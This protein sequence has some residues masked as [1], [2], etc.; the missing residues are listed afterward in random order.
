MDVKKLR[1]VV[2]PYDWG[3]TDFLPSLLGIP[4][5][6]GRKAEYWMGSHPSGEAMLEH[7]VKLSSFLSSHPE[8]CFGAAHIRRFGPVL[9]FLLKVLS[10]ERP[11][12][13]QCHPTKE[14]AERGW[15]KEAALRQK[16]PDPSHWDY[17]DGNQKA[18]VLYALTPVTAMCAFRPMEEIEAYLSPLMPL[19]FSRWFSGIPKGDAGL[20][21]LFTALYTM[22]KRDLSSVIAEYID[23]LK[24][25]DLPVATADGRFLEAKGIALSCHEAYPVDP[26][27]FCPF[28]LH[29]VHLEPGEALFLKPDTLHAYVVGDGIELMSAS[30]NVLR[31]GLTHKKVDVPELLSI[32]EMHG[33]EVEKCRQRED[34]AGRMRIV[35]PTPDF[36]LYSAGD[37]MHEVK[38]HAIELML[39]TEGKAVFESSSRV[40]VFR[41]GECYLVPY[42][43]GPYTLTVEGRLF[44]ATTGA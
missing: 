18:E 16:D 14:Q 5:D 26:G 22:D 10:I 4:R 9:P 34:T 31:G 28:L 42:D 44:V 36:A 3:K 12:S 21:R 19:S 13:I 7:G 15:T 8:E 17:Q 11:L 41:K 43:A 27:L 40:S 32:L 23:G 2:K 20:Q 30:D 6:G 35:T 37:G 24:R 29:V 33:G 39:V 25:S 1:G 38:E